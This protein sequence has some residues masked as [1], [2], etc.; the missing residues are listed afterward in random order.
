MTDWIG[1]GGA[2]RR[3]SYQNRARAFVGDTL[4]CKGRVT[5]KYLQGGERRVDCEIWVERQTG[6]A[7]SP[8]TATV[9]LPA[10]D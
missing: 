6:E 2:L 10:K 8:G 9:T 3:I 7:T 4:T 5:K 1:K